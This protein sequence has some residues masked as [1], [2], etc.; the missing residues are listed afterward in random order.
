MLNPSPLMANAL[1]LEA[2]LRSAAEADWTDV[3]RRCAWCGRIADRHGR[4]RKIAMVDESA[5]YTDGMCPPCGS[6]GLA[7]VRRRP[8]KLQPRITRPLAA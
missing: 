4:Y 6:R 3:V 7:H 1:D 8:V 2:L 5:V